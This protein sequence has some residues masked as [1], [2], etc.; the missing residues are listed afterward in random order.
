M[1]PKLD[2]YQKETNWKEKMRPK[3]G[4]DVEKKGGFS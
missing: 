2:K 3:N 4:T 1:R